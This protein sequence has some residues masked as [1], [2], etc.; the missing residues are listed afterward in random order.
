MQERWPNFLEH[1]VTST[2]K[3]TDRTRRAVLERASGSPE[4]EAGKDIPAPLRDFADTVAQ[5][6]YRITEP[7]I[8]ALHQAGHS[9]DEIFEA[10]IVA[11]A[12]AA[13]RHLRAAHR[14]WQ[15]R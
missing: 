5:R 10:M 8:A 4:T 2:G 7:D 6:S 1:L 11:A 9:D 15:E 14:V 13:D 12:G 3:L